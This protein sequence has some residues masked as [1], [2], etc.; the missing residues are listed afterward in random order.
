MGTV[1]ALGGGCYTDGEVIPIFE[2]IV[3]EAG[4]AHPHVVFLPTAGHDDTEG[5]EPIW[6]SFEALGCTVETL[7]LTDPKNSR[8]HIY[9]VITGADIIYAGGGNLEFMMNT[10]KATGADEAL[11]E[12]Y[13]LG[14]VLSG[15]SSG[16]MCWFS[17]GYDDCGENG[18]F[19]FIDCMGILP[20]CYCPHF[21][22]ERW[23]SFETAVKALDISGVG[24]EDGAALIFKD[25]HFS[26][27]C[28]NDG[29]EVFFFDKASGFG[30]SCITSDASVLDIQ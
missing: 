11:K 29:G 17:T 14:R 24:V 16:A 21:V 25:G 26:T 20:Y 10:F 3:N 18:S 6:E 5:D 22:S 2:R 9:E 12:A 19:V 7:K 8:E 23:R 27:M 4:K 28:G 15:L 1:I 13:R 30:K